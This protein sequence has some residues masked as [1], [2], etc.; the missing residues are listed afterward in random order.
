VSQLP[1]W[2]AESHTSKRGKGAREGAC[3]CAHP[4]NVH[5]IVHTAIMGLEHALDSVA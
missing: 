3:G 4:P 1:C 5:R 2:K